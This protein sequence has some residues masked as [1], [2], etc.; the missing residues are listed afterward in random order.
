MKRE[1]QK[2]M[3]VSA[4]PGFHRRCGAGLHI[5]CIQYPQNVFSGLFC[6][7]QILKKAII[8]Q[9]QIKNILCFNNNSQKGGHISIL[10]G[11]DIPLTDYAVTKNTEMC[12]HN[13]NFL[14]KQKSDAHSS[15]K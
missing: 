14:L 8:S 4:C 1:M 5:K 9:T 2:R 3:L 12:Q 13:I 15:S 7:F 6:S 10:E 11:N